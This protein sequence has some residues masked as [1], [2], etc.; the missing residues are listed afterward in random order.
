MSEMVSYFSVE[1]Q[2]GH[3]VDH[4]QLEYN[5]IVVE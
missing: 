3:N 5:P 1:L 4:A 2:I